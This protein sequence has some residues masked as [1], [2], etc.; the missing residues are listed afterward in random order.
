MKRISPPVSCVCKWNCGLPASQ[1]RPFVRTLCLVL[2]NGVASLS[3]QYVM[4]W[5]I[6]SLIF[7]LHL[8]S[9]QPG[10]VTSGLAWNLRCCLVSQ[11][12][13]PIIKRRWMPCNSCWNTLIGRHHLV[14][15]L[16]VL[17]LIH[18][19]F[20]SPTAEYAGTLSIA[21]FFVMNSP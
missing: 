7:R 4:L 21:H 5:H 15:H 16:Q 13:S 8:K 2:W 20:H 12:S 9:W 3:R 14:R 6:T 1:T 11:K 17:L 19:I 18:N 10:S